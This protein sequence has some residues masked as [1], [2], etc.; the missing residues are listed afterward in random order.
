[1]ESDAIIK[2][3]KNYLYLRSVIDLIWRIIDKIALIQHFGHC[4]AA[5]CAALVCALPCCCVVV[6]V[7]ER[8]TA[9]PATVCYRVLRF[10]HSLCRKQDRSCSLAVFLPVS[11]IDKFYTS[12]VAHTDKHQTSAYKRNCVIIASA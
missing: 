9:T 10:V 7:S 5:R 6:L 1:M 2:I 11:S 8:Y 12:E 4:S 3:C